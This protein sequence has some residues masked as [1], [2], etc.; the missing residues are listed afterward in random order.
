MQIKSG[1]NN[2]KK[3][4]LK[5]KLTNSHIRQKN[6]KSHPKILTT[7]TKR[8]ISDNDTITPITPSSDAKYIK[9][10]KQKI[11]LFK[12]N[13][14]KKRNNND[15]FLIKQKLYSS[16]I[17]N[18]DE[19]IDIKEYN[20]VPYTQALRIDK[21]TICQIFLYVIANPFAAL[22]PICLIPSPFKTL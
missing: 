15:V 17:I 2:N 22:T 5:D 18:N 13:I 14:Q 3:V 1:E 11:A 4:K 6:R 21:R 7:L 19:S 9:M 8:K 12:K 16:F 20:D 10:N